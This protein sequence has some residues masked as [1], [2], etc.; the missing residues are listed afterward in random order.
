MTNARPTT[1]AE[2]IESSD[3]QS[4]RVVFVTGADLR[5]IEADPFLTAA[6]VWEV[7]ET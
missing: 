6:D 5:E 7:I 4:H 2:G 1:S 3:Q